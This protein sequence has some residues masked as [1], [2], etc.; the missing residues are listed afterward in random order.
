MGLVAGVP[1]VRVREAA[2]VR[3]ALEIVAG[4]RVDA[5]ALDVE[6][7]TGAVLAALQRI[8]TAAPWAVLLALGAEE[9]RMAECCFALG[10]NFYLVLSEDLPRLRD[11]L[12]TM[13]AVWR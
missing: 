1:N 9:P 13:A 2:S 10:A 11:L 4:E 6:V 3:E 8:R 12:A 7:D 5:V